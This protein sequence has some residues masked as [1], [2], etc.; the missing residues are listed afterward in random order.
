MTADEKLI[1]QA[2]RE[3]DETG[4]LSL[5]LYLQLEQAGIDPAT[6]TRRLET[7]WREEEID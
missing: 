6:V 5:D 4:E 7:L 2:A 1:D 3:I